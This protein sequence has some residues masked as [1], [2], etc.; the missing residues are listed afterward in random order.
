MEQSNNQANSQKVLYPSIQPQQNIYFSYN[1]L[2]QQ[3]QQQQQF[4]FQQMP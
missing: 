3:P 1:N 4:S 2:N